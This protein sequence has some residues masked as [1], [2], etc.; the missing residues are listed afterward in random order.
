MEHPQKLDVSWGREPLPVSPLPALSPQG[1]ERVA[2][3]GKRGWFMGTRAIEFNAG[4]IEQGH[5]A[6][7]RVVFPLTLARLKPQ[8]HAVAHEKLRSTMK[9]PRQLNEA[10]RRG[11]WFALT[12]LVAMAARAAE[13]TTLK[14]VKTI[15]L[16][17]VK[18]RLDHLAID[19]KGQRLFVAALG[20]N[21]VEVFDLKAGK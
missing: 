16:P 12:C 20:N 2:A 15:G 18:G 19:V 3:G 6:R 7:D 4:K 13:P 21:T 14:L 5:A 9:A 1:G 10:I 8:A 11:F 17:D